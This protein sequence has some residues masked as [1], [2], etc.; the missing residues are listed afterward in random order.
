MKP[1]LYF[2]TVLPGLE[3][4]LEQEIRMKIAD[5]KVGSVERGKVH[6]ASRSPVEALTKLR[7][8]DNL[9][10]LVHRFRVG[11]HKADLSRIEREIAGL[12]LARACTE[13]LSPAAF[14]VNAG[15]TGKHTYSRF[16]AAEAAARG[17]VRRM[18]RWARG[19]AGAHDVEFRLDL[20]HEDALFALKLTDASFR[21]RTDRRVFARAALR[22]T[23][24]HALVLLSKPEAAD[25]FVDPC[26]GSGT[27]V[28]ERLAYP[29]RRIWGGDASAEAV[30][31]ANA[32]IGGRDRV[33]IRRWDA[34]QLPLD[35]ACAD[36][37]AANLPFGR[38]I[39][40]G[41]NLLELYGG[42]LA[43]TAR[44]LKP[45]GLAV[46]LTDAE[47]PLLHAAERAGFAC[48]RESILSLKGLHP[49][50]YR[51]HKR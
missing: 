24:A 20:V 28:S 34:R 49:A 39:A 2:A 21:Y 16:E 30:E 1:T 31:A 9:Y 42:M 36:K 4:V 10:R 3:Y 5:A 18:A 48:V 11:P 50:V 17:V 12:D 44:V 37:A 41:A 8:A 7:T 23:V 13:R 26:C 6:F 27:I 29:Y 51:L 25:R 14:I 45:G 38:Q 40:A 35:A 32:N 19:T 33:H 47:P 43:E 15:R 22:P 46:V